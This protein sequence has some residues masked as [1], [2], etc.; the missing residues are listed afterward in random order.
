MIDSHTLPHQRR[1]SSV[2]PS[3]PGC[4]STSNVHLRMAEEGEIIGTLHQFA[5]ALGVTWSVLLRCAEQDDD[6]IMLTPGNGQDNILIVDRD[7]I[8]ALQQCA[9][10]P[11]FAC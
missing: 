8:G 4:E 2:D 6:V 7:H 10:D 5:A 1:R 9:K 3:P 11:S